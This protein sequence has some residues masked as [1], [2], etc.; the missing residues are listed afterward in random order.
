MKVAEDSAKVSFPPPL[1]YL[2]FL[3]LGLAADRL[4]GLAPVPLPEAVR[5]FGGAL[6]AIAGIA[7][8]MAG[9]LR[10]SAIGTE[11]KPWLP[12]TRLA[13]DG[14]YAFTRNPMYLGMALLYAGIALALS[15]IGALIL[16]PVTLLAIRT[17]VI[18]REERY[19]EGKFGEEYLAYKR[20]V[21]RWV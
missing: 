18:A 4:F 7:V 13:T 17:Q 6:L 19:L 21:R 16:L 1:V 15:S 14:I 5:Y 10:F 2:G 3:L 8:G 12:A 20:R 9:Q 11:V